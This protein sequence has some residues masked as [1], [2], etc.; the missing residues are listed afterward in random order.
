VTTDRRHAIGMQ[1]FVAC[2]IGACLIGTGS[3][4]IAALG[5][6]S[7]AVEPNYYQKS[8]GWNDIAAQRSKNKTLGW[9]VRVSCSASSSGAAHVPILVT[10]TDSAGTPLAG[11]SVTGEAFPNARASAR[12][13]L[14]FNPAQLAGQFAATVPVVVPGSIHLRLRVTRGTDQFTTE[15]DFNVADAPAPLTNGGAS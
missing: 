12:T 5:D 10:I 11:A 1:L 15:L 14:D 9:N 4:I 2:L 6:R 7:F 13:Q 3:L 8:L